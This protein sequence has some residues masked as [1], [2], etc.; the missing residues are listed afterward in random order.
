MKTH[1]SENKDAYFKERRRIFQRTKTN[2]NEDAK[3]KR[4]RKKK[5]ANAKKKRRRKKAHL[6]W[7]NIQKPEDYKQLFYIK[8]IDCLWK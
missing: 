3:K 8:K 1:I 2:K 7:G 4:K 5:G 6:Y